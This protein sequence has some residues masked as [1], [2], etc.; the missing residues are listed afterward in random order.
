MIGGETSKY[1]NKE[2]EAYD[3][4]AGT[5]ST[6]TPVPLG[7]ECF[8]RRDDRRSRLFSGRIDQAGRRCDHRPVAGIYIALRN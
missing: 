6:L 3:V 8:N 4:K 2:N 5:W 1:A 7:L